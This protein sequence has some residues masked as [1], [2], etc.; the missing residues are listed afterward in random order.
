MYTL[1]L[2]IQYII[3]VLFILCWIWGGLALYVAGPQQR[4]LRYLVLTLF[5]CALPAILYL[6]ITYEQKIILL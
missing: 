1:Q 2:S 5:I 3:G 4:W 6:D